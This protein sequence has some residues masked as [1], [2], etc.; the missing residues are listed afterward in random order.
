[1]GYLT[2]LHRSWSSSA[3]RTLLAIPLPS[4]DVQLLLMQKQSINSEI[5]QTAH[6]NFCFSFFPF[7]LAMTNSVVLEEEEINW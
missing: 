3:K 2:V 5:P 7:L 1:M 4:G 6:I